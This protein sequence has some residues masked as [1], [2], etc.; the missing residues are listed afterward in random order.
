[1]LRGEDYLHTYVNSGGAI[2]ISQLITSCGTV[3]Q[4]LLFGAEWFTPLTH[5]L[6]NKRERRN[7]DR[8]RKNL[9]FL[10]FFFYVKKPCNLIQGHQWLS[11]SSFWT[12]RGMLFFWN[13]GTN[14][15]HGNT[16]WKRAVSVSVAW[17]P[18]TQVSYQSLIS[19]I[20]LTVFSI[21]SRKPRLRS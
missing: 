1:M 9:K 12:E 15:L 8:L 7:P 3:Y 17:Y 10:N 14:G 18:H 13:V 2:S 11:A 16:T 4:K 19:F 5:L 21:R 20:S 6:P